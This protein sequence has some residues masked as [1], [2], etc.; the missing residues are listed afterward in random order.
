PWSRTMPRR[1]IACLRCSWFMSG[2]CLVRKRLDAV[3][4]ADEREVAEDGRGVVAAARVVARL[5][6]HESILREQPDARGPGEV[7]P[8][9]VAD[10]LDPES[11]RESLL[12]GD[13]L[14]PIPSHGAADAPPLA[15]SMID[16]EA[17]HVRD[18]RARC[19]VGAAR[20]AADVGECRVAGLPA[21]RQRTDR[22]EGRA[23]IVGV[24]QPW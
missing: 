15:Q 9:R 12:L 7:E 20:L 14:E 13:L 8:E 18:R 5:L 6:S 11:A 23:R 2:S 24:E 16:V 3:T 1:S 21:L 17:D 19:D 22:E 10:R 4:Q